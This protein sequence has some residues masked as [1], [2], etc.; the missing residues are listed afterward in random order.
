MFVGLDFPEPWFLSPPQPFPPAS[1]PTPVALD[2]G[3][4]HTFV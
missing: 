2:L 4:R 3:G 1:E